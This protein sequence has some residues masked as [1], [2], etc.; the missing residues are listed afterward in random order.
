MKWLT[1]V[2]LRVVEVGVIPAARPAPVGQDFARRHEPQ[3]GVT[4][5]VRRGTR[6]PALPVAGGGEGGDRGAGWAC[7]ASA[8]DAA[9]SRQAET[10]EV[11]R[12]I[13]VGPPRRGRRCVAI[14]SGMARPPR[15]T[16][17]GDVHGRTA[18]LPALAARRAAPLRASIRAP[19]LSHGP[20]PPCWQSP[21]GVRG[22]SMRSR[23]VLCV[24]LNHFV[25]SSS[26]SLQMR[27]ASCFRAAARA[28][29]V[30]RA[31]HWDASCP[32]AIRNTP[33]STS[34]AGSIRRADDSRD[35]A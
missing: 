30:T 22:S 8:T 26:R 24:Q 7:W 34:P 21:S 1:S 25:A 12:N 13:G 31:T 4:E 2:N 28:S 5:G 16:P 10:G 27:V 3:P 15:R 33:D 23:G 35:C 18:H 29:G 32:R 17:T 19:C 14:R 11:R 20:R 6:V 9:I